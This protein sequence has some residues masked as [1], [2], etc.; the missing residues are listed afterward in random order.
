MRLVVS[1]LAAGAVGAAVVWAWS[2]REPVPEAPAVA[3]AQAPRAPASAPRAA[4]APRPVDGGGGDCVCGAERQILD[5]LLQRARRDAYGVP[6]AWPADAGAHDP[7]AVREV[8]EQVVAEC[9][10]SADLQAVDCDEPPCVGV[11]RLEAGDGSA[12]FRFQTCPAWAEAYGGGAAL[13]LRTVA[14]GDESASLVL[15]APPWP[16]AELSP[17]A[18]EADLARR[19]E[20][21][22]DVLAEAAA[23]P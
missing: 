10:G 17:E 2:P 6:I 4:P 13:S 19:L 7:S 11:F 9:G 3:A 1:H 14:C 20:H 18:D 21:R 8:L 15:L 5:A 22:W 16:V 12:A 23:C